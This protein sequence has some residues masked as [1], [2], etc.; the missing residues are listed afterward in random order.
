M[1][2]ICKDFTNKNK[3]CKA[4]TNKNKRCK[5]KIKKNS[6][7][8]NNHKNNFECS[9]CLEPIKEKNTINCGHTFCNICID[10]WTQKNKNCP[11]CRKTLTKIKDYKNIKNYSSTKDLS[12]II[13]IL[14][15]F[16]EEN[17]NDICILK[18]N[19]VL[20]RYNSIINSIIQI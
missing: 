2:A 18:I 15:M 5:C 10:K 16:E 6:N 17:N 3:R 19:N 4:I 11:I 13:T 12:N 9:I 8:C 1:T 20:Y 14:E 7:Y